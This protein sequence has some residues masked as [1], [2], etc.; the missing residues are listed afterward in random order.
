MIIIK[1]SHRFELTV[2]EFYD[3][4]LATLREYVPGR[5]HPT[6]H[7]LS[8]FHSR[9]SAIEGLRRRWHVLFPDQS[10]LVWRNASVK[11]AHRH[12]NR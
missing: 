8:A 11:H 4:W 12:A 5:L 2:D 6:L 3:E 1:D 9:E 10:P 7:L